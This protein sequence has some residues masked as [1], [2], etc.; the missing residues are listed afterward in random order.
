[1]HPCSSLRTGGVA[2]R[3]RVAT[4]HAKSYCGLRPCPKYANEGLFNRL[5]PQFHSMCVLRFCGSFF[6]YFMDLRPIRA[7]V[8]N[9]FHGKLKRSISCS[10]GTANSCGCIMCVAACL[11]RLLWICDLAR[12]LAFERLGGL[13]ATTG[14]R[15]IAAWLGSVAWLQCSAH[16]S[17]YSALRR[18]AVLVWPGVL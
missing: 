10:P 1:M 13:K 14:P 3:L 18:I 17:S 6:M 12:A 2:K 7:D 11:A 9:L 16:Q 5:T 8:R 15:C 4:T